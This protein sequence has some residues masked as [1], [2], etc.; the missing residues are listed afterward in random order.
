[1]SIKSTRDFINKSLNL[2]S[3]EEIKVTNEGNNRYSFSIHHLSFL[4]EED[5]A[6][7]KA[8]LWIRSSLGNDGLPYFTDMQS[9]T[10]FLLYSILTILEYNY[11]HV[12]SHHM[13][14]NAMMCR[15]RFSISIGFPSTEVFSST[16]FKIVHIPK[17]GLVFKQADAACRVDMAIGRIME[18]MGTD[19]IALFGYLHED[20]NNRIEHNTTATAK[21]EGCTMYQTLFEQEFNSAVNYENQDQHPYYYVKK[22]VL[23]CMDETKIRQMAT[24][25]FTPYSLHINVLTDVI[26]TIRISK[27]DNLFDLAP[28]NEF[29]KI[30]FGEELK[31]ETKMKETKATQS[32]D[33]ILDK[34][35]EEVVITMTY[36]LTNAFLQRKNYDQFT[37]N[38][39]KSESK[40]TVETK[41]K[42][43]S[44]RELLRD[45]GR[46]TSFASIVAKDKTLCDLAPNIL[47][48]SIIIRWSKDEQFS[49]GE[50][51][52]KDHDLL[53]R[54]L[55][56]TNNIIGLF[57]KK[58][59][60]SVRD[61][62]LSKLEK[63]THVESGETR[64]VYRFDTN[65]FLEKTGMMESFQKEL[66]V[67]LQKTPNM[68]MFNSVPSSIVLYAHYEAD[69]YPFAQ[70]FEFSL[71]G[72]YNNQ[73]H[74]LTPIK[75]FRKYIDEVCGFLSTP[76][77][78]VKKIDADGQFI[79]EES[80]FKKQ[81][82]SVSKDVIDANILSFVSCHPFI[83]ANNYISYVR[84]N[85]HDFIVYMNKKCQTPTNYIKQLLK[86]ENKHRRE[87]KFFINKS[88]KVDMYQLCIGNGDVICVNYTPNTQ[89]IVN[90]LRDNFL[91]TQ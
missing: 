29:M 59:T 38:I 36:S 76:M 31:K 17:V 19:V 25:H 12:S 58:K 16:F 33:K 52:F 15:I 56:D 82:P 54:F 53:V 42:V 2:V 57:Y 37:A 21:M 67:L 45:T 1:M 39:C 68:H 84:I 13:T 14:I 69:K 40:M 85:V 23:K 60:T 10:N 20:V 49:I 83:P 70:P 77:N 32:E 79:N 89:E 50:N 61:Y 5:A 9:I 55:A 90:Y 26:T 75:I 44:I 47:R 43:I 27:M 30:V 86:K 48:S 71:Y 22:K 28:L 35:K 18:S 74:E 7:N 87:C 80:L 65:D 4:Y 73:S 6:T 11:K 66:G 64:E 46:L 34:V 81:T 8:F 41:R 78:V 63:L 62:I 88:T 72:S 3:L 24:M 91:S 51:K